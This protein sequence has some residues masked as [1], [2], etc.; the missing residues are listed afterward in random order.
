MRNRDAIC[1][2]LKGSSDAHFTQVD[3]INGSVKKYLLYPV[4]IGFVF[5]K[6]F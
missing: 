3:M 5:S 4:K 1:I 2:Y 6:P